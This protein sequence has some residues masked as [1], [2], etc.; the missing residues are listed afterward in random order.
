MQVGERPGRDEQDVLGVDD[1]EVVLVPV[2]RDVQRREDLASFQHL[3]QPLL[4]ALAA[5]VARPGAGAGALAAAG[6]LVDLVDEH[7]SALRE[8]DVLIGVVQQL[9]DHHLDVLAVV[10]GL[11]VLG[12][13]GDRERDIEAA[14]ERARDVR[15]ARAGG[16]EQQHV[17]LLDQPLARRGRLAAALEV[18][19]RGDGDGALGA[20]LADD[21][22]IEVVEDLRGVSGLAAR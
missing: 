21:V 22:A 9:A 11:R 5:D 20:L 19:V 1:D 10:A 8:L 4:N 7:D 15:L 2:L 12:G 17:G 13:V 16:P 18:V 14:G 6:D 3:E